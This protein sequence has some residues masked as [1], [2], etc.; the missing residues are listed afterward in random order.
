MIFNVTRITEGKTKLCITK[1][2]TQKEKDPLRK[3]STTQSSETSINNHI[4]DYQET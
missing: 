1:R 3:I 2:D 4:V